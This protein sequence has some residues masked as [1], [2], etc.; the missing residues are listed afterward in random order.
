VIPVR[1]ACD[2]GGGFVF[3][4]DRPA[5]PLEAKQRVCDAVSGQTERVEW[6]RH[7][8]RVQYARKGEPVYH[9]DLPVYWKSRWGD[10]LD[11][12]VGKQH[13]SH[14][15]KEWQPA[16]PKGLIKRV[17]EYGSGQ[18][19][20]QFR[21]VVRYLKRWTDVHFPDEG[22]ASPVGIGLTVAAS[23]G[24]SDKYDSYRADTPA[25]CDD[26][27]ATKALV[28]YMRT[29]F[30]PVHQDGEQAWRLQALLPVKP[31]NDVFGRMTNQQMREFRGRIEKLAVSLQQAS[32]SRSTEALLRAFGDDFPS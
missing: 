6:M 3:S 26:L 15:H 11:L 8:I 13:S 18:D 21:R 1:P 2:G 12:A 22:N 30:R 17:N 23:N 4:G 9:V 7:C 19:R 27:A 24:F 14:P 32:K 31:K 5:D 28:D 29:R 16:D 20:L 10:S 25:Q